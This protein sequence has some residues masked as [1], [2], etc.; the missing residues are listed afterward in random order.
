MARRAALKETETSEI[1]R[2]LDHNQTFLS[3]EVEAGDSV[4]LYKQVEA[5]DSVILDIDEIGVAVKF[6][7]CCVRKTDGNRQELRYCQYW[8][9]R[10][11]WKPIIHRAPCWRRNL[12]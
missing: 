2:P 5:G 10:V 1:R 9:T 8:A 6:Q 7:G 11:A 3:T 4:I 12:R